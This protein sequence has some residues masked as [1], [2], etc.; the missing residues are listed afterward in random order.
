MLRPIGAK[1]KKVRRSA[2]PESLPR[3]E[4]S[5]VTRIQVEKLHLAGVVLFEP[6]HD[7]RHFEATQSAGM[8][9][10]NQLGLTCG[11]EERNFACSYYRRRLRTVIHT[12]G[13]S[14][15]FISSTRDD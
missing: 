12:R 15:M 9:K 10:L 7:G 3:G 2:E 1:E 14:A 5:R 8:E 13:V 11:C 4:R 6:V